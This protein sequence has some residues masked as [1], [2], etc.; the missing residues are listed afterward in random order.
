PA[1]IQTCGQRGFMLV[2]R[3]LPYHQKSGL[4]R[5]IDILSGLSGI[6]VI[7]LSAGDVVR[8]RLVK[9]IINAYDKADQSE[10]RFDKKPKAS[11]GRTI[12][13]EE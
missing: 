11:K 2:W 10:K 7:N 6:G 1:P 4:R 9:A 8:H 3:N 5:A 13:E 12:E